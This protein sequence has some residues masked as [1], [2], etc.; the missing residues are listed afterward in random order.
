MSYFINVDSGHYSTIWS[1]FGIQYIS[2]VCFKSVRGYRKCFELICCDIACGSHETK[3]A[4]RSFPENLIMRG[5]APAAHILWVLL[6]VLTAGCSKNPFMGS[7]GNA[8]IAP[9]ATRPPRTPLVT[10]RS[11]A[12]CRRTGWRP[13]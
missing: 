6:L 4:Q 9:P 7:N 8:R 13:R 5:F 2:L 12:Q 3:T 11:C 1:I 10:G